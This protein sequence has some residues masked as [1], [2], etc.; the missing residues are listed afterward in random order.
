MSLRTQLASMPP[1]AQQA[2]LDRLAACLGVS[3]GNVLRDPAAIGWLAEVAQ[4][5]LASPTAPLPATQP[6]PA[7]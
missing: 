1:Q 7:P 3:H 2:L 4:A 6:T 5:A